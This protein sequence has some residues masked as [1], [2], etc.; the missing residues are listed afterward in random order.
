[1]YQNE[2][3]K[4]ELQDMIKIKQVI[5][6]R[7]YGKLFGGKNHPSFFPILDQRTKQFLDNLFKNGV[8]KL[9]EKV[10]YYELIFKK[11]L[12]SRNLDEPS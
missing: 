12:E 7:N 11:S 10:R 2:E 4:E 8:R 3:A 6:N 1:L 9:V 5:E